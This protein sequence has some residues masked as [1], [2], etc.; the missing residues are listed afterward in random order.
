MY[1]SLLMGQEHWLKLADRFIVDLRAGVHRERSRSQTI[2]PCHHAVLSL[3]ALCTGRS[4]HYHPYL[5]GGATQGPEGK[6]A[7]P[8]SPRRAQSRTQ[9]SL[10]L[11]ARSRRC[12]CLGNE[13]QSRNEK[14]LVLTR[15][16]IKTYAVSKDTLKCFS[17]PESI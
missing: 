7:S 13:S 4:H 10:P 17:E 12:W 3:P 8:W 1:F 14:S 11:A 9:P 16:C 6:A 2:R 15:F 5:T